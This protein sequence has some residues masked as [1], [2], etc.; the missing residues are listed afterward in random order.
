[1][2]VVSAVMG[3]LHDMQ[4]FSQGIDERLVKQSAARWSEIYKTSIPTDQ[5]ALILEISTQ[6]VTE[7][8]ACRDLFYGNQSKSE[9]NTVRADWQQL[10]MFSRQTF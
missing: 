3:N 1:M 2:G 5:Y 8:I 6:D 7:L 9:G 10:P 4:W